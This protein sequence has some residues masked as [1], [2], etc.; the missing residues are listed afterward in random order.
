MHCFLALFLMHTTYK[1]VS[2][3]YSDG[4]RST[5][6]YKQQGLFAAAKKEAIKDTQN[7]LHSFEKLMEQTFTGTTDKALHVTTKKQQN[8]IHQ[9]QDTSVDSKGSNWFGLDDLPL[10]SNNTKANFSM[11]IE[12]ETWD[13]SYSEDSYTNNSKVIQKERPTR[14]LE[15]LLKRE[16]RYSEK[17]KK[18]IETLP[19]ALRVKLLKIPEKSHARIESLPPAH[20]RKFFQRLVKHKKEKI[21]KAK[22]QVRLDFDSQENVNRLHGYPEQLEEQKRRMKRRKKMYIQLD[23]YH[24]CTKMKEKW[25]KRPWETLKLYFKAAGQHVRLPCNVWYEN[26][27]FF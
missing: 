18:Y 9:D 27:F 23:K 15:P 10:C 7:A 3:A 24:N 1:A 6:L 16:R 25:Y 22:K 8:I 20:Q 4:P 2:L 12:S 26:Y 19:S 21:K 17:F 13:K 5:S 11:C 14:E